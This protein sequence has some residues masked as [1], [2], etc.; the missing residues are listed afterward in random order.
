[1]SCSSDVYYPET[2][3][4]LGRWR[5]GQNYGAPPKE[6][7]QGLRGDEL[8]DGEARAREV[9][10]HRDRH[11]YGEEVRGLDARRAQHARPLREVAAVPGLGLLV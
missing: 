10:L 5:L 7:V 1:M 9:P 6:A 4:L 8:E 2:T 11:L 3:L